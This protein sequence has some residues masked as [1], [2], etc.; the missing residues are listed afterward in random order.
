MSENVARLVDLAPETV[1]FREAVLRGLSRTPKS[2][3]PMYF[4][5]ERG[6]VLFEEICRLPEYYPTRAETA[7]LKTHAADIAARIG[8]EAHLV[9]YGS[10]ATE[11]VRPLLD[12]LE[13]PVAYTPVDISA[14]QLTAAAENLAAEYPAH[15]VTGII[16][17]YSRPF[18]LPPPHRRPARTRAALFLGSTIGNFGP[19][20]ALAF[21]QQAARRL[22]NGGLLLIG[23]DLRKDPNRLHAAYN[24]SAGVTAH[25]N[26][27]LLTRINRELGGSF[28]LAAF[29][30]YAFYNPTAGRIE[31]HLISRRAQRVSV[32]G[33]TFLFGEGESLHTENSYKFTVEGFRTMA[34]RA[35]FTPEAVWLDDDNLFSLHLLRAT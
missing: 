17:D 9:E 30:H 12:A 4:Y 2:I 8:P 31:M 21:L 5:D 23:A 15:E 14:E 26:L 1:S 3:P 33:E 35:G 16:A 29:D 20:E 28:D 18:T 25:F 7:I 19:E 22:S 13:D 6:A 10:G 27:N 24:D 11:K 34:R 32:A